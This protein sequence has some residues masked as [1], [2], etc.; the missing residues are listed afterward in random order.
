M[1][2]S[3]LN[4]A[5][6]KG[7][8][9]T[10][11]AVTQRT[12]KNDK[13][14]IIIT[15]RNLIP[16]TGT[17]ERYGVSHPAEHLIGYTDGT[18]KGVSGIEAY[19]DE[20][21]THLLYTKSAGLKDAKGNHIPNT[22]EENKKRY[23]KLTLDYHIQKIGENVLDESG[24]TGA[25]VV[26]D[27]ES[28]D[29][30]AMVS[31]PGFDRNKVGEYIEQGGTELMNRAVAPYN[32]GSIF[33]II[34]ASAALEEESV[35]NDT[36]FFCGG[37]TPI[38]GIDFICHHR[39]GHGFLTLED[40][41]ASSCNCSFYN[42]GAGVGCDKIC[43]YARKFGLGEVVLDKVISES[44]GNIPTDTKGTA[45]ETANIS[46]GQGEI[47][48]TPVQA[49][50]A[51]CI[52][53]SGG[54]KRDVNIIEGI[55]DENGNII[56]S[57]RKNGETKI[58]SES[59]ANKIGAMMRM[60]TESGTGTGAESDVVAI[61]GKTGSAETGWQTGNGYMV[62]GWYVGY[63]PYEKPKYALVVMTEN[64]RQGNAS[65]GPIFKKTAEEI[66][67]LNY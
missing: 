47:L 53:A 59:T 54:K 50:Q 58:L 27:V 26:M 7:D 65:C 8:T 21:M 25:L 34:T 62:Q 20:N 14:R 41:F 18:G 35:Y 36:L 44:K 6:F 29:I 66:M 15:D 24:I 48:I 2:C 22:N 31:R 10:K 16:L 42:I 1:S 5:V 9:Y 67:K 40:A 51:V 43:S 32:A 19:I 17:D 56:H 11:M 64:G 13:E 63:F 28:G 39:Q 57:A 61:A 23:V 37:S 52:I 3:V 55:A 46:I 30:L 45:S 49:A 4:I 60:T 12:G 33:K 38:D